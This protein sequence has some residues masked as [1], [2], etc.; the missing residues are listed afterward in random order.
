MFGGSRV[1]GEQLRGQHKAGKQ[2]EKEE[3]IVGRKKESEREKVSKPHG[4]YGK[5]LREP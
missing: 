4:A 1:G 2:V 5:V 3:G